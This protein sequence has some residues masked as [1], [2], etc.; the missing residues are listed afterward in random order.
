MATTDDDHNIDDAIIETKR[1]LLFIKKL[2]QQGRESFSQDQE[3]LCIR[4][5]YCAHHLNRLLEKTT[6]TVTSS[7]YGSAIKKGASIMNNFRSLNKPNFVKEIEKKLCQV[8]HEDEIKMKQLHMM[9]DYHNELVQKSEMTLKEEIRVSEKNEEELLRRIKF[10]SIDMAGSIVQHGSILKQQKLKIASLLKSSSAKGKDNIYI[11]V[12]PKE[13]IPS[14]KFLYQFENSPSHR[15]HRSI[16]D[17]FR[18]VM[19][20]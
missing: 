6:T 1:K 5:H 13:K 17:Q 3:G 2:R 10:V 16:I 12:I 20:S 9:I 7:H 15:S 4:Q 14:M 11:K 19:A 8:L 18:F